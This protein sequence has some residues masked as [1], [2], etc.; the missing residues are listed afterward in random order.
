M[1]SIDRKISRYIFIISV[2]PLNNL[3]CI[4]PYSA[5]VLDQDNV[6]GAGCKY[7]VELMEFV[8]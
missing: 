2:K 6:D 7:V 4:S 8:W 5:L 1:R 3:K